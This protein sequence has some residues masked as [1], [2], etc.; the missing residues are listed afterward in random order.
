MPSARL[1]S[2]IPPSNSGN[3]PGVLLT[4]DA[5]MGPQNSLPDKM[6]RLFGMRIAPNLLWMGTMFCAN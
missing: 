2:A 6:T 4:S 5:D 1:L 3:N